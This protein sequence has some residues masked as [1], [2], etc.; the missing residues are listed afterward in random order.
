MTL[1]FRHQFENDVHYI[2]YHK[3]KRLSFLWAFDD[4]KQ[5]CHEYIM[6]RQIAV[7]EDEKDKKDRGEQEK[8]SDQRGN[9]GCCKIDVVL[10]CRTFC[11]LTANFYSMIFCQ[12]AEGASRDF[13]PLI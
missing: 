2:F 5:H 12:K 13:L 9:T 7:N 8:N 10:P 6:L 3:K 1:K 4:I 11:S